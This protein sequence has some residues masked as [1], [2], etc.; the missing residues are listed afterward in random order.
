MGH[1]RPTPDVTRRDVKVA[2]YYG[3]ACNCACVCSAVVT[4]ECFGVA[5]TLPLKGTK[6]AAALMGNQQR[7][8]SGQT[9]V[10]PKMLER[11]WASLPV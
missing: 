10:R 9:A 8:R 6:R 7:A 3:D 2:G 11:R 5:D 4:A 1:V